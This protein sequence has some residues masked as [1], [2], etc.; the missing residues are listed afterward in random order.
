MICYTD[1][2]NVVL[3]KIEAKPKYQSLF[4]T[5]RN[6][7]VPINAREDELKYLTCFKKNGSICYENEEIQSLDFHK[8]LENDIKT[9]LRMDDLLSSKGFI[10][11]GF[12]EK[13]FTGG[14]NFSNN[15]F[16][17]LIEKKF[18]DK[19]SALAYDLK[20]FKLV[21]PA[22]T[23][24]FMEGSVL[25]CQNVSLNE[26]LKNM[27][28]NSYFN[29]LDLINDDGELNKVKDFIDLCDAVTLKKILTGEYPQFAYFCYDVFPFIEFKII[30]S[31][32]VKELYYLKSQIS[33]FINGDSLEKFNQL[34]DISAA[35]EYV[36][37]LVK[38]IND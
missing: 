10:V 34:L 13:S 3:A 31:L 20:R 6:S 7:F 33:L 16:S 29:M 4:D 38:R 9:F 18:T 23:K 22:I 32:A 1:A 2:G 15:F 27:F 21:Y 30:K 12:N 11:D 36:L 8:R 28:N 24:L 14:F 37:S 17:I 19:N 26:I 35:N 25:D 5:S